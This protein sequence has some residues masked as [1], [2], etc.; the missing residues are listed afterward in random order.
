MH[1]A[2]RLEYLNIKEFDRINQLRE[3]AAKTLFGLIEAVHKE[4][5]FLS[6]CWALVSSMFVL[7]G[8][9]ISQGL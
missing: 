1:L 5:G 9:K 4:V 8:I 3:E 6:R 2:H 7:H